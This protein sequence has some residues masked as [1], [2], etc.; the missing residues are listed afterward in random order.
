MVS[1]KFVHKSNIKISLIIPVDS[2]DVDKFRFLI[3]KLNNNIKYLFEIIAVFSNFKEESG[4]SNFEE[5][6]QIADNKLT[7]IFN[8]KI[9]FP[10]EARNIGLKLSKGNFIAFLDVNTIPPVNWLEKSIKLVS[11]NESLL[12]RTEYQYT[13]NFNKAFI[14]ATYG[15]KP[16]YTVPGSLI[17]KDLFDRVGWFIPNV[18]SGED[19]DW[20]KRSLYFSSYLKNTQMPSVKYIGLKDKTFSNLCKKWH[21]FCISSSILQIH[22]RQKY[23]YLLLI[24]NFLI[25]FAFNWNSIFSEW[26][27][28]NQL[29]IPHV[30][31]M[32][33]FS[34]AFIYICIR[35]ILIPLSKGVKLNKFGFIDFFNLFSISVII[36][37]VKLSA[38]AQSSLINLLNKYKSQRK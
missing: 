4:M 2:N 33:A 38:F 23:I 37:A 28:N 11:N 29:Y 34:I 27:M 15:F 5:I 25:I 30:T 10:G 8:E 21:K 9:C 1:N 24:T 32:T 36:D 7:L 14:S 17:K 35:I 26:D 6:S 13:N 3:K 31:K 12:G 18:R 16:L 20:I 19:S 22:Q